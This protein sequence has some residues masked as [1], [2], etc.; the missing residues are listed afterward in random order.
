MRNE[1]SLFRKAWNWV[2]STL[3]IFI[4]LSRKYRGFEILFL[5][6]PPPAYLTMLFLKNEFSVLMWDV[7]PDVLRIMG[8]T[9]LNFLYRLWCWLNRKAFDRTRKV[10]TIGHKMATSLSKYVTAK[11][12]VIVPLW[13]LFEDFTTIN[14]FDNLFIK[15]YALQDKFIV[16]YSGNVGLTHNIDI[17][18]DIAKSLENK[19]DILF[20]IIARGSRYHEIETKIEKLYLRNC[21]LLPFQDDEIFPH[22]LSAANVGVVLLDHRASR[23]SI[24]SKVYNLM[25]AGKPILYISSKDSELF[26]YA[27]KY[28]NGECF[29]T[30]E[31]DLIVQYILK[32]YGSEKFY[33]ALSFNSVRASQF[34]RRNN[35]VRFVEE[36]SD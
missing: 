9:R 3:E 5:P 31:K 36:L 32:L 28:E 14:R 1:V 13:S 11:K 18:L 33:E 24:P 34:Y 30:E 16:Q 26:N 17:L 2:R 15:K 35:A 12:I 23:D 4:L 29:T 7:Y 10:F 6:N 22:S 20:Q 21:M 8:F 25:I 27:K 19:E